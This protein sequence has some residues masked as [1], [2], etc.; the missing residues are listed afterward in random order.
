MKNPLMIIIFILVLFVIYIS[1]ELYNNS[2]KKLPLDEFMERH[3]VEYVNLH[4]NEFNEAQALVLTCIDFR[5]LTNYAIF[6]Q[7]N[8]LGEDYDSY[9]AAGGSLIFNPTIDKKF[10]AWRKA[11]LEH[12]N[13]VKDIHKIKEVIVIDHLD[14][15][16]YKKTYNNPNITLEEEKILHIGNLHNFK[17]FMQNEYPDLKTRTYLMNLTGKIEEF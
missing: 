3:T 4:K 5:F 2:V 9:I 14:C 11:F 17:I 16:M 15:G 10:P 13:L 12:V 1:I 6:L 7:T 8:G